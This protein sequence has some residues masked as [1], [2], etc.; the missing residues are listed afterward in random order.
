MRHTACCVGFL[1]LKYG[2]ASI[3]EVLGDVVLFHENGHNMDIGD[4]NP[5]IASRAE[6]VRMTRRIERAFPGY[7]CG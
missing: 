3:W 7:R 4:G 2:V 6:V 5:R 1:A